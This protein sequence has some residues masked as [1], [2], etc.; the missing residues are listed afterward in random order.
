[1]S[2]VTWCVIALS[3]S[4]GENTGLLRNSLQAKEATAELTQDTA[5]QEA[6]SKLMMVTSFW[7]VLDFLAFFPPLLEL[8]LFHGANV[9]FTLGQFDFRWF[10]ILR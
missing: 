9:S 6:E 3:T 5:P 7:N 8:C 4:C 2:Y 1:M 10:K